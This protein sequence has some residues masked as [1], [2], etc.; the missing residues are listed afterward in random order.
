[1]SML[2]CMIMEMSQYEVKD[3]MQ[4]VGTKGSVSVQPGSQ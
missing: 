4:V 1:M 2:S 3:V